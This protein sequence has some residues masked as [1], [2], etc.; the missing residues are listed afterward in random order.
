MIMIRRHC[1]PLRNLGQSLKSVVIQKDGT[2]HGR[3]CGARPALAG[4]GLDVEQ[5]LGVSPVLLEQ[6]TGDRSVLEHP[7]SASDPQE[8]GRSREV[9]GALTAQDVREGMSALA[10]GE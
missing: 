10:Q 7:V 3:T 4:C 9:R 1:T 5:M 6:G 2:P 8:H